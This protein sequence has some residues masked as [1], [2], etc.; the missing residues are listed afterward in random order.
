[1]VLSYVGSGGALLASSASQLITFALLAR[2]FG[3]EQFALYTTITALTNLGV[4]LCGIGSQE[5]LVRRVAQNR[6]IFPAMLGH[7]YILSAV[8]G[9]LLFLIGMVVL[10]LTY[11]VS[12]SLPVALVA[13]ALI[14]ATNLIV[15]KIIWISTASFMAHFDFASA[16]KLELLFAFL[17]TAAA[18]ASCL[19][20]KISTVAEWA[21]WNF[22][23]HALTAMV[24]LW[25][26]RKLGKPHFTIVRDEIR[27]GFMFST[28]FFFRAVRSNADILVL[29]VVAGSEVLGSYSIARRILDSSA[30]SIEALNRL[31]YPGSAAIATQGINKTIERALKIL[32][33]ALFISL[34]SA[35]TIW[36]LA[37]V[38]P[39]LFGREYVS[40][41]GFTRLLCWVV[42]PVA[43]YLIA[44]EALGASGRQAIRAKIWNIGNLVGSCLVAWG[45]WQFA[46]S[47]TI[48]SY[49]LVEA[50][51]A[52]FAWRA[53]LGLRDVAP[54][55]P[56]VQDGI[57]TS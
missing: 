49:Y 2:Y 37:P 9:L 6:D 33:A 26:V 57:E 31:I 20:F 23:A 42:I 22:A 50:G 13:T 44:F 56:C 7:A 3:H 47:G 55:V 35:L 16:N 32:A 53:L 24:C 51:M 38:L 25:A 1:M 34:A 4:Q 19:M 21:Y 10:P 30:L 43:V 29:S 8:T 36:L 52:F 18:V 40:L 46:V 39:M 48:V 11:R 14:L 45:T 12:P 17:R 41:A 28:Q 54:L 15:L 27:I 5:S